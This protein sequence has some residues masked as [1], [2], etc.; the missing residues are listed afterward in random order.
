MT[1]TKVI[2]SFAFSRPKHATTGMVKVIKQAESGTVWVVEGGEEPYEIE[3]PERTGT[4][5]QQ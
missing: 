4:R 5:K 3:F 1:C 2:C